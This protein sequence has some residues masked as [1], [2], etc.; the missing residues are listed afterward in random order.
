MIIS[1]FKI[2]L[3][4]FTR[5]ITFSLINLL[6]LSIA[7]FLFILLSLF[8]TSEL[9][10]DKHI[11]N[12]ENIY[13]LH[14][15]NDHGISTSGLFAPYISERY[16]EVK[17]SCVSFVWDG[18]FFLEDGHYVHFERYAAVDSN[19][20]KVFKNEAILGNL[21]QALNGK[22]GMVL[23]QS[24][25]KSLFANKNPIGEIVSLDNEYDYVVNAVIPDLPE[26]SFF[27]AD[28]FFISVMETVCGA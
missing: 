28:C 8:I 14:E 18:N 4:I 13:S 10:T 6:G 22:N 17:E 27:K 1:Y 12:V 26:N 21:V 24:A 20:F 2:A 9:T 5:N 19:Y 15:K 23:T 11:E 16:P 25:A 3:R 7:F